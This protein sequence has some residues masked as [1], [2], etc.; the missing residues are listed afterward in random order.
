MNLTSNWI[1]QQPNPSR[2]RLLHSCRNRKICF[3]TKHSWMTKYGISLAK[4]VCVQSSVQALKSIRVSNFK[5]LEKVFKQDENIKI[6]YLTR[7]P[8]AMFNSRRKFGV[9][10]TKGICKRYKDNYWYLS[11]HLD[12]DSWLKERLYYIRYEDLSWLPHHYTGEIYDFLNMEP[13]E[14]LN[15]WIDSN[16]RDSTGEHYFNTKRDSRK[17]LQKWR[18]QLSWKSVKSIQEDC[19]DMMRIFGYLPFKNEK[20]YRDLSI[21]YFDKNWRVFNEPVLSNYY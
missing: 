3:P 17:N 19:S 18:G 21:D 5:Q 16:T 14:N 1:K 10:D 15:K 2:R 7:D 6:L 8:R 11:K 13:D 9:R 20:D 12:K 4:D